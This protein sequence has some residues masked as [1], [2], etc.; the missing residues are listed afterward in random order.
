[1]TLGIRE[2]KKVE[3]YLL[4]ALHRVAAAKMCMCVV[5]RWEIK[6]Y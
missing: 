6:R 5:N 1:M 3:V 2:K 4:C